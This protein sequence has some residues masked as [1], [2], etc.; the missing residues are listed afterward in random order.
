MNMFLLFSLVFPL[1]ALGGLVLLVRFLTRSSERFETASD[2][3]SQREYSAAY[4]QPMSRLLDPEE[5]Q[6][7]QSLAGIEAADFARFRR[8]RLQS[9]RGYLS[10]L[11]SDFSR[12]EFQA[13]FFLLSGLPSDSQLVSDLNQTKF[14]FYARLMRVEFELA[15]FALGLGSVNVSELVM[16]IDAYQSV[17]CP[18]QQR[19][20]N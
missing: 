5:L 1:L 17:L 10:D 13:R 20:S 19:S 7:A 3:S 15:L 6:A 9:F 18:V 16:A 12:L 8:A 2:L 11:R 4:Y 14:R